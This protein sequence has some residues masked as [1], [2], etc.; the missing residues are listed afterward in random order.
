MMMMTKRVDGWIQVGKAV[1]INDNS[2]IIKIK[3]MFSILMVEAIKYSYYT[4]KCII[5]II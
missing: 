1:T 3:K 5:I 2:E 4:L